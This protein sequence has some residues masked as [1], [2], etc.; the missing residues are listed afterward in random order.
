MP[1]DLLLA[2]AAAIALWSLSASATEQTQSADDS[3]SAE[4]SIADNLTALLG[5]FSST[6][7]ST[8]AAL[9]DPNV[10]AFLML[11]R[12]GESSTSNNAYAMLYG[13]GSFSGFADHPRQY[14]TVPDGR[15][16]SAAGAYQITA[17]TW[18]SIRP[19]AGLADFSPASQDLAAVALIKRRGALADVIAGRFESAIA[20]CRNEWT[21]LPGAMESRYSLATA[22]NVLAQYGATA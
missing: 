18:D 3:Q 13:G 6:S 7:V 12:Y 8:D 9:S 16:T 4:D 15:R 19:S 21:S 5:S 20:K 2:A 22:F 17:T 1:Y 10:R 11:I 14:F